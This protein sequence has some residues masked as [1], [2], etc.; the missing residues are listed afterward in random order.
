MPAGHYK[1]SQSNMGSSVFLLT[2]DQR[3]STMV[4]LGSLVKGA[5]DKPSITFSLLGKK[6]KEGDCAGKSDAPWYPECLRPKP[7]WYQEEP[8]PQIGN[9]CAGL[10]QSAGPLI[11]Q[12]FPIRFHFLGGTPAGVGATGILFQFNESDQR[13]GDEL[14]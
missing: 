7:V 13:A 12:K 1:V 4:Q 10:G 8:I 5:P 11:Q 9:G 3:H 14:L 6:K 2:D